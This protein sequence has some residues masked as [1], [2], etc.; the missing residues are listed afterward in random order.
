MDDSDMISVTQEKRVNME[1]DWK[2][3]LI[4]PEDHSKTAPGK[5]SPLYATSKPWKSIKDFEVTRS[6]FDTW[7]TQHNG[8]LKTLDDWAAWNSYRKS[9][10]AAD[11]GVRRGKGGLV[12]QAK[13]TFLKAYTR[14]LWGLPGG[15]YKA[16]ADYLTQCGYNTTVSDLKNAKRSKTEPVVNAIPADEEVAKLIQFLLKRHPR[17]EWKKLV[18][19]DTHTAVE[20]RLAS[21]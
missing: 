6:Q 1:Y 2:R 13:S 12:G 18:S 11:K 3:E 14:G 15:D 4:D 19:E 16:V 20:A 8:L 10:L 5:S 17:F 21:A 9:S 7:R